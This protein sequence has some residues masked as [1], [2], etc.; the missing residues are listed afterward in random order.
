MRFTAVWWS[1]LTALVLHGDRSV[2]RKLPYESYS[3]AGLAAI[4]WVMFRILLWGI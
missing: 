4:F 3:V 1:V 2:V